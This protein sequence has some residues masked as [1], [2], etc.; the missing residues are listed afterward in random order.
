ML[1][2]AS[3]TNEVRVGNV[4]LA[5]GGQHAAAG[6]RVNDGHQ[7]PGLGRETHSSYL[8]QKGI[9]LETT[10]FFGVKVHFQ[11]QIQQSS[12]SHILDLAHV[13]A[14]RERERVDHRCHRRQGHQNEKSRHPDSEEPRR[15]QQNT[16][17]TD[18]KGGSERL[19]KDSRPMQVN[20]TAVQ[21]TPPPPPPPL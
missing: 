2:V 9:E 17:A 16:F 7:V 14:R 11:I 20:S 10:R 1:A 19:K 15:K 13:D 18:S 12:R 8:G 5:R 4:H 6:R 21:M 3:Q